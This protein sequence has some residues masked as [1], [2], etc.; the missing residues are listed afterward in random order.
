V[1]LFNL[2]LKA[3]NENLL[4]SNEISGKLGQKEISWQLSKIIRKL[5]EDGLFE[6]SIPN[7]PN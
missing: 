3:L 7:K 4:T 2:V 1:S 5:H 6:Q